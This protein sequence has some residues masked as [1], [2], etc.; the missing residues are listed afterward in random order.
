[1]KKKDLEKRILELE[2]LVK[3]KD[4]LIEQLQF[5][6]QLNNQSPVVP[7]FNDDL[8]WD[9]KPHDYPSPWFATTPPHCKKCGKQGKQMEITCEEK[10]TG[11]PMDFDK[12]GG[13]MMYSNNT[14]YYHTKKN[15]V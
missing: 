2:K 7:F 6:L 13:N 12:F 9:G 15:H 5:Q 3:Q 11:S 8:C 14:T 10:N 1:M 4:M